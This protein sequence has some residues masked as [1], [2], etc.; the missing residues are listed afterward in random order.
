MKTIYFIAI[1]AIFIP[2]SAACGGRVSEKKA[3]NDPNS[4][5]SFAEYAAKIP[6]IALP[7]KT[8]CG[9]ELSRS[10]ADIPNESISKFGVENSDV[11]G[12]L[13]ETKN[14][15]TIVYLY[16][17]DVIFPLIKTTD[18]QGNTISELNFFENYCGEDEGFKR[19][20]WG[21]IG[22]NLEMELCDSIVTY[23]SDENNMI[24]GSQKSDVIR[25]YFYINDKG[26]ILE[27]K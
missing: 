6:S 22:K 24:E 11:Y 21:T 12:K 26:Q 13:A 14:Y 15:T 17:G 25:R 8:T 9:S 23:R 27:R 1:I 20:S 18:K 4:E 19:F 2:A 16:P 5:N 3:A 10:S 7:L